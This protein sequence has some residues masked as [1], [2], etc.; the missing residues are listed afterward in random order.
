MRFLGDVER[1]LLWAVGPCG[2]QSVATDVGH[3]LDVCLGYARSRD[4]V[5]WDTVFVLNG[6]YTI[7]RGYV[8]CVLVPPA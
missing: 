5:F 3:H 6:R 7:A 2:E 4:A 1:A 8:L